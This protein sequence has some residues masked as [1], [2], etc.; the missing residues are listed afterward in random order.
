MSLLMCLSMLGVGPPPP[1][2]KSMK[3]WS[4]SLSP[5]WASRR[6]ETMRAGE[7]GWMYGILEFQ[8]S[9]RA[10]WTLPR[11][12]GGNLVVFVSWLSRSEVREGGSENLPWL[13]ID[14]E[15]M[16]SWD[17]GCHDGENTG[18]MLLYVSCLALALFLALT[19]VIVRSSSYD[20]ID[21]D[22]L[23]EARKI[24]PLEKHS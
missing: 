19:E 13:V 23:E 4:E 3:T 6:R 14:L 17:P 11:N 5:R 1:A 8:V 21:F 20:G 7:T 15:E 12:Q 10:A 16:Q 24:Y 18:A 9:V 22:R 2:Q